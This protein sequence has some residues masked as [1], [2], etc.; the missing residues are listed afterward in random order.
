MASR[1][2]IVDLP[3][4]SRRVTSFDVAE[5]AGVSQSTVSR[6]LSGSQVITE[7]TRARV[8]AAARELGY[9]VDS[10]AARLR[11]GR[12]GAIGVVVIGRQGDG[13]SEFNPFHYVLLGS[14]CAAASKAGYQALVSFQATSDEFYGEYVER[15]Q[16]DGLIVIGTTLNSLAWDYFG[17]IAS[18]HASMAIWGAPIAHRARVRSDNRAGARLA[19]ARLV[20]AGHE[21]IVFLGETDSPQ[22]QFRERYEGYCAAMEAHGLVPQEPVTAAGATRNAQGYGAVDAL[23]AEGRDFDAVFSACD[24]MALGAL[25]RLGE[26]GRDVPGEIGV[27]GFDG[28][29]SGTYSN[30]PLTTIE[31]DF[32]RAGT[33]LV[34]AALA[35]QQDQVEQLVPVR[36]IERASVRPPLR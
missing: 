27:I 11:T 8:V 22:Q 15:G 12:T 7:D 32:Q 17:E 10:R 25:E 21:R 28:L 26:A 23:L 34:D 13:P 1:E 24:A 20:A 33:L 9:F 29:G 18:A 3:E 4:P 6:A 19:I 14:I 35:A 36:L 16:A 2:P 5:R 30:P 31:P